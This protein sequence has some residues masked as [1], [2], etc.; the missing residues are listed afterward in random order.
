MTRASKLP[1]SYTAEGKKLKD[2]LLKSQA[3]VTELQDKLDE[4]RSDNDRRGPR[5]R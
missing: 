4:G 2:G 5:T 1:A 3:K